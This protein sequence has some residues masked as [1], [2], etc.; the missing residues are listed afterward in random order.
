MTKDE[1]SSFFQ[2]ITKLD[3]LVLSARVVD[4]KE[5]L[6]SPKL[7][8]LLSKAEEIFSNLVVDETLTNIS[9]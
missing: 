6:R 9:P 3:K 2:G 5:N 4:E 8:M 7:D 1:K